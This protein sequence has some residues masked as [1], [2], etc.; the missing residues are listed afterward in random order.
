MQ[1]KPEYFPILDALR[2]L[3]FFRIFLLHIPAFKCNSFFSKILKGGEIGV[4]FFFV[5]SGFL[6]TFLFLKERNDTGKIDAKKYFLRRT[7]RIWPLYFMAILIGF[8]GIYFSNEAGAASY[9]GYKPNLV[10]L[11]TF[12]ENYRM[13]ISDSFPDGAPLRVL[14]SICVEEHFYILWLLLFTFIKP[15]HT[16]KALV[17]LWATGII[18]RIVFYFLFPN[19]AVYDPDLFSKLDYFCSGSLVAYFYVQYK[20]QTKSVINKINE[21]V[22]NIFT[23]FMIAAFFFWQLFFEITRKGAIYF[24]IIS[25][26][27]FGIFL[28]LTISSENFINK[29]Y[30]GLLS[31]LGKISYGLYVYHTVV[32]TIFLAIANQYQIVYST[33][34]MLY[35]LFILASLAGSLL[36]STISYR[37]F[38][39][40]FLRKKP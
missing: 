5:L 4:D 10:T 14:W 8:F 9:Y 35:I 1:Q 2:F 33:N 38:E 22:R 11:L 24:P 3:A 28:L 23:M 13:I 20:T 34:L 19:K 18:Y 15:S 21:T 27:L 29:H 31:R 7:L 17:I 37:Y 25:A 40:Y 6:I 39:A 16:V 12:T 26:A 36:I 32:I 30:C